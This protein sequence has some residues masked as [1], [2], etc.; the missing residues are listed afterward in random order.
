MAIIVRLTEEE[1][2]FINIDGLSFYIEIEEGKDLKKGLEKIF[3]R[4]NKR[5]SR[6]NSKKRKMPLNKYLQKAA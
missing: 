6:S 1:D 3:R 2:I 5:K 4:K